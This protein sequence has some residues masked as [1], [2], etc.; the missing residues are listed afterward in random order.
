VVSACTIGSG[1]VNMLAFPHIGRFGDAHG[2]RLLVTLFYALSP[3]AN[4]L[5]YNAPGALFLPAYFLQMASGLPLLVLSGTFFAEAFPVSH[6]S[7]A[8]SAMTVAN[9]LGGLLGLTCESL[10][11]DA[12]GF[13]SH[14]WAISLLCLAGAPM[15][16][17][18]HFCMPDMLGHDI[19]DV[20]SER[21]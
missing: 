1:L 12:L 8:Q 9:V 16:F 4:L 21:H 14:S 2:R 13:A 10:L 20:S 19:D 18:V 15:P 17:I 3:L 5:F 11:Y 7:T 6:R